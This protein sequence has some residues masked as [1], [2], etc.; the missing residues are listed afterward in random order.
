MQA[1][2]I[3]KLNGIWD[4]ILDHGVINIYYR[5]QNYDA[6]IKMRVYGNKSASIVTRQDWCWAGSVE[7]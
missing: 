2:S 1:N 7:L 4:V 6:I 5:I 3:E